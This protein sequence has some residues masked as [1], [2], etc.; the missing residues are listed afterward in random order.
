MPAA[1]TNSPLPQSALKAVS[2]A[3]DMHMRK[4]SHLVEY[5]RFGDN[6]AGLSEVSHRQLIPARWAAGIGPDSVFR[7]DNHF[8]NP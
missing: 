2:R 4:W 6:P 3:L 7:G 5:L 8:R 1:S